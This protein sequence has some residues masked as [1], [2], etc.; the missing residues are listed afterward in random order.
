M[1]L[2]HEVISL[3]DQAGLREQELA[4]MGGKM[5]RGSITDPAMVDRCMQGVEV[6]H[7]VAA[8]F[9][10]LDVVRSHYRAV[11]V[12]G[13]RLVLDAAIRADFSVKLPVEAMRPGPRHP[14]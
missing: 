14:G 9:R 10:K 4:A 12:E 11:N 13:T 8:S 7:H 2:G 3:D 5:I 6:V 1:G